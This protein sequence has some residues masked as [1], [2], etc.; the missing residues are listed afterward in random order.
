DH[1]LETC[2]RTVIFNAF[3]PVFIKALF[4]LEKLLEFFTITEKRP[5]DILQHPAHLLQY[6][7]DL[8]SDLVVYEFHAERDD[9]ILALAADICRQMGAVIMGQV[10]QKLRFG[11]MTHGPLY[12]H[13]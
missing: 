5:E 13:A 8:P 6:V 3:Q 10:I 7:E 9:M 12:H 2:L 1:C 11:L 4:T